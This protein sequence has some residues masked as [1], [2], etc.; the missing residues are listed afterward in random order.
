MKP[1][2]ARKTKPL[3]EPP[4]ARTW[5]AIRRACQRLESKDCRYPFCDCPPPA[6]KAP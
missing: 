6:E 2:H 1:A 5:A 3:P 4:H